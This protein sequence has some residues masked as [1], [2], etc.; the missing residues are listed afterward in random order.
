MKN[1]FKS[2]SDKILGDPNDYLASFGGNCDFIWL[3]TS[4]NLFY[5]K[6]I[7]DMSLLPIT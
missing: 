5:A 7:I 4:I 6:L 2:S 3:F 1:N